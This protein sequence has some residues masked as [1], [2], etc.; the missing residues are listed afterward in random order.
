ME[1]PLKELTKLEKLSN[2]KAP[3]ILDSLDA[4]LRSLQDAKEAIQ[5]GDTYEPL[6]ALAQVVETRKKEVDDRQKE[7]Y[8]TLSRFGKALDKV[9]KFKVLPR[10]LLIARVLRNSQHRSRLTL[11]LSLLNLLNMQ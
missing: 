5:A 10:P 6:Q 9:T 1:G 7:V 8:S 11:A 2:G 4:L 3:S